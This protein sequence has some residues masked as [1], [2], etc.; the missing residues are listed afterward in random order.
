MHLWL[1]SMS[2]S[3]RRR[4]TCQQH[5]SNSSAWHSNNTLMLTVGGR[6]CSSTEVLSLRRSLSHK[7][8]HDLSRVSILASHTWQP[9]DKHCSFS[10]DTHTNMRHRD[11][12]FERYKGIY[13]HC[14]LK[15]FSG[16]D[17]IAQHFHG[18]SFHKKPLKELNSSLIV[19]MPQSTK[20]E[21][22][23]LKHLA[24]VHP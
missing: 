8:S 23:V 14:D 3:R 7:Q 22:T 11:S 9:L 21:I 10:V 5:Y 12:W 6:S 4:S 24:T 15:L 19:F 20:N 17:N 18:D 2:L 13:I 1:Y 16:V